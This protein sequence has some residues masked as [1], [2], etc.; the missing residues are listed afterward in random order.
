MVKSQPSPPPSSSALAHIQSLPSWLVGRVAA[1]GRG[2]VADAIA[3][4][5]LKLM[6]H[7]VLAATAEYGPVAQADLGRRLAV[8][9]KDMVGILN[10]LQEAGLVLRAPDP[11]DR[12]KN[13]VTVT[14]EGEAALARCATLAEEAN[15]QLLAP[16]TADE[17]GVLMELLRRVHEAPTSF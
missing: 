8:D 4:E 10:H 14:P 7:A 13:A 12:R 11:A 9:P 6:Q 5:G 16:L 15:E 1:R 3:A 2:L 17:Q